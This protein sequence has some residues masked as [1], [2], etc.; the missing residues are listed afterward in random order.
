MTESLIQLP[1]AGESVIDTFDRMIRTGPIVPYELPG[2][3]RA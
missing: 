2:G 3:V 1:T